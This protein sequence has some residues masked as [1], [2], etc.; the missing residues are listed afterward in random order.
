M[1]ISTFD[2][3]KIGI[4]PSSSHTVGPMNAARQFALGLDNRGLIGSCARLSVELYGSLGATGAGHGSPM[5]IILGLEG[6]SP[7]SVDVDTAASR[8]AGVREGGVLKLLGCKP[9][10]FDYRNDLV[11]H[12]NESLPFHANGMRFSAWDAQGE[13]IDSR[14]FYSVGGG[15]IVDDTATGA[16]V[17]VDDPTELPYPF[18]T[19]EALLLQCREHGLSISALM[20]ENEKAWRGA[21]KIRAGLLEL[22]QVMNACIDKGCQTEGIMPGGL[23]VKRRA[24]QLYRQLKSQTGSLGDDSL[25]TMDWVTLYALAVNEENAVGGRVVSA[26]TYVAAGIIHAVL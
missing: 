4:G 1:S 20:L 14:V 18:T 9:L 22:W 3:F 5:A 21:A 2:L 15:F 8:V 16:D 13:V 23:K 11:M 6:E 19:A 10:A 26:P 7:E 17:V 12:R 25:V 24:A